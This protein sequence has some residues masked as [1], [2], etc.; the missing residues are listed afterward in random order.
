MRSPLT[1]GEKMEKIKI[2][3]GSSH[4]EIAEEICRQLNIKLSPKEP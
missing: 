2:F 1:K 4:P 3:S